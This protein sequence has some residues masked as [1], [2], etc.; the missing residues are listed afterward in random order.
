MA[1]FYQEENIDFTQERAPS[2]EK[3]GCPFLFNI[4]SKTHIGNQI[5]TL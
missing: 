5:I 2:G 1:M 3:R 4:I